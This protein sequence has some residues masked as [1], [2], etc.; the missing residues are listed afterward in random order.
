[1]SFSDF[2]RNLFRLD[3]QVDF[4]AMIFAALIVSVEREL[5][6]THTRIKSAA[7]TLF[8]GLKDRELFAERTF[9]Y[10]AKCA[11]NEMTLNRLVRKIA[12]FSKLYPSWIAGMKEEAITFAKADND[13]I[14]DRALDF[15]ES[16]KTEAIKT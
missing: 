13:G 3:E 9:S 11:K 1:M 15:I 2:F 4:Y 14:Q 10:I 6:D 7:E 16:L 5:E 12:R 8:S